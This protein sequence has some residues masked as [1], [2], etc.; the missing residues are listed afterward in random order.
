M[1]LARSEVISVSC[2]PE[3]L[4]EIKKAQEKQM[5]AVVDDRLKAFLGA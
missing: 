5:R 1:N 2:T 4:E 3:E